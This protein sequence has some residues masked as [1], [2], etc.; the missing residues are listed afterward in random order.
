MKIHLIL[1]LAAAMALS[2]VALSE[3]API[4]SESLGRVEVTLAFCARIDPES[5][6]KYQERAKLFTQDH[7][8]KEVEAARESDG[9]RNA[10]DETDTQLGKVSSSEVVKSCRAFLEG[11]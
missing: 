5:A 3:V 6:A 10:Y 4:N 8:E 2:Q 11:K 9:Y 7:P 1:G